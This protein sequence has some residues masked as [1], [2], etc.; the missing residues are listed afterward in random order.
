MSTIWAD[1]DYSLTIRKKRHRKPEVV[2]AREHAPFEIPSVSAMQAEAAL[3]LIGQSRPDGTEAVRFHEGRLYAPLI[4]PKTALPVAGTG[5]P[6]PD[7]QTE[8]SPADLTPIFQIKGAQAVRIEQLP[9]GT[10]VI[11]DTRAMDCAARASGA[12]E[13]LIDI[14]GILHRRVDEPMLAVLAEWRGGE[15]ERPVVRIA[16]EP[17]RGALD[18]RPART[19]MPDRVVLASVNMHRH[20]LAAEIVAAAARELGHLAIDKPYAPTTVGTNTAGQTEVV[21]PSLLQCDPYVVSLERSI[22]YLITAAHEA[23]I[24]ANDAFVLAWADLRE[25]RESLRAAHPDAAELTFRAIRQFL[26]HAPGR[27]EF[28]VGTAY[29]RWAERTLPALRAQLA[30]ITLLHGR[31]PQLDEQMNESYNG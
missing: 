3:R 8:L 20:E 17:Y 10:E 27:E 22:G 15:H 29:A 13:N 24:G 16:Y 11:S 2:I 9:T 14:E 23:L 21:D 4:N 5:A 31:I 30:A 19:E 26:A 28:H 25:C 12:V 1:F 6:A 7:A 18:H